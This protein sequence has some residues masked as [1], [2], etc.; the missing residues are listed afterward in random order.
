MTMKL[1]LNPLDIRDFELKLEQQRSVPVHVEVLLDPALDNALVDELTLAFVPHSA[2]GKS[3]IDVLSSTDKP[4]LHREVDAVV[5]VISSIAPDNPVLEQAVAFVARLSDQSVPVVVVCTDISTPRAHVAA[6]FGLNILATVVARDPRPILDELA[7]WFAETL[8]D[9]K[10]AFAATFAWMRRHIAKES[11]TNT[12]LQNGA[13]GIVPVFPGADLPVMTANQA[14]MILQIAAAYGQ[15]MDNQ[16]IKELAAVVGGGFAFREVARTAIGWVPVL[17][18]AIS[19]VI[20]YTGTIAMGYAALEYFEQGGSPEGLAIKLQEVR[21]GLVK[22]AQ[23]GR[24]ALP[25]G[26]VKDRL[27]A[28]PSASRASSQARSERIRERREQRVEKKRDKAT[29]G[30]HE[31]V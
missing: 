17:G 12:A 10:M 11:I 31:L 7:T 29:S 13:V 18:W 19:G 4:T 1:P 25:V 16:R 26:A 23:K 21:D 6:V 27:K 3:S 22:K 28:L 9:L 14:K 2:Q 15:R 24:A 5:I 20:G 8:S 30:Y